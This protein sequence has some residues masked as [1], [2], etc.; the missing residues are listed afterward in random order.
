MKPKWP[1]QK[2]RNERGQSLIIVAFSIFVLMGFVGLAV[3]VG[4]SYV[5]RVRAR[6]A[7]DAA[8]LAAAGELPLEAAA[9]VRA[10]EYLET[11]GYPCG[12]TVSYENNGLSYN[13]TNPETR[14][15]I[16]TGYPGSYNNGVDAA[17]CRTHH[18]HQ[19]SS[20]SIRCLRR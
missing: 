4:I 1:K 13:C 17:R 12:L 15:E 18:L 11:N 6:R 2:E 8:A 16:N 5:D 7:A 19:H 3:D 10:L 20:L 14:I 9:Q